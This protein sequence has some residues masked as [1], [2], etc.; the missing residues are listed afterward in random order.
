MKKN[1]KLFTLIELITAMAIF[2]ILMVVMMKFFNEAQQAWTK[3]SQQSLVYENARVAMDLIARDLQCIIYES[4]KTP[5]LHRARMPS[6]TPAQRETLCFITA[7]PVPEGVYSST[8]CELNYQL[9]NDT[10]DEGWLMRSCTGNDTNKWNY[11]DNFLVGPTGSTNNVFSGNDESRSI[12]N[13]VIPYVTNLTFFCYDKNMNLISADARAGNVE[14]NV[15][16]NN[17]F[18]YAIKIQL[19]LMDK[20]GWNKWKAMGGTP[21]NIYW[22]HSGGVLVDT[23]PQSEFRKKFER[24]FT[25]IIFVD[26]RG[27]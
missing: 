26:D 5:F 3:T 11:Y 22:D 2:S 21:A 6:W 18:P 20:E 7:T 13:R 8:V 19:S 1:I 27:Q 12:F 15:G 23:D 4:E 25:K 14:L 24:T 17:A 9:A 16:Q 10:N